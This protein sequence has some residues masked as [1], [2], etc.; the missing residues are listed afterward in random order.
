MHTFVISLQSS[1]ERRAHIKKSFGEQDIQYHFFDAIEPQHAEV[2]IQRTDHERCR[3]NTGR[4]LSPAEIACF[5][6]HKR[7][8][9]LCVAM[10]QPLIVLEDDI[11]PTEYFSASLSVLPAWCEN[12]GYVRL[13]TGSVKG[14][15][16]LVRSGPF[17]L[18]VLTRCPY[19]TAAYAISPIT[20]ALL[21]EASDVVSGPVDVFIK[22]YWEHG[23]SIFRIEPDL[24]D[25]S[26]H[27]WQPT[28][29]DRNEPELS[30]AV[31]GRRQLYKW[32][33]YTRRALFNAR[34]FR[35]MVDRQHQ[36]GDSK[37]SGR[38]RNT[39]A[40]RGVTPE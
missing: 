10:K 5:A 29:N 13:S 1:S 11:Q 27:A 12:Y 19:S 35:Q 22:Q 25:L 40:Q 3:L 2:E 9:R 4:S 17:T 39:P 23:Q 6:S 34:R 14:Q 24:F 30:N 16:Q 36:L 8:W 28:I 32:G 18:S 37:R 7:L 21:L 26:D 31:R 20:A 15:V 33:Q 38:V